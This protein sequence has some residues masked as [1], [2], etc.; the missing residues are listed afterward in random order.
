MSRLAPPPVPFK[1]REMLKGY[2]E[3]LARLQEVLNE[4]A[5]PQSR[6][7]PF[8]EA[9]WALQD[10][11]EAF[12]HEAEAEQ[13]VAESDNDPEAV[14]KAKEKTS[15]MSRA[16]FKHRWI[17]DEGLEKYFAENKKAFE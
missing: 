13:Q 2:P 5:E 12:M 8:D 3:Y 4:F 10:T 17:D 9:V 7:Q 14:E 11:L 15:L 1:L 6:V 16:S